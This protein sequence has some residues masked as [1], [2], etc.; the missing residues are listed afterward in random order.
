MVTDG[1]VVIRTLP[2]TGPNSALFKTRLY[3]GQRVLVLEGPVEADGYPWYRIRLG[4][5]EGWVAAADHDGTPWLSPVRNGAIAFAHDEPDGF[6][7]TIHTVGPD[8]VSNEA[9]LFSNES[10]VHFEQLT[11]SPDGQRLAFVSGHAEVIDAPSE[12]F[13]IDADGSNL[14]QVTNDDLF[15]DSPVWSPDGSR[16][17]FHQYGQDP[18]SGSLVNSEVV[19]VNADGSGLRV[20]GPGENPAWSPDGQSVAMTVPQGDTSR[21]WV[22]GADG[23]GRH[24]VSDLAVQAVAPAWSPDGQTLLVSTG[25]LSLVDLV[26]GSV[27]PLLADSRSSASPPSWS[28]GGLIAFSATGTGAPGLFTIAS[29]GSGLRQVLDNDSPEAIAAWSPD[30]RWLILDDEHTG[31][32]VTLVDAGSGTFVEIASSTGIATSAAWQALLP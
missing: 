25:G 5:I 20:L 21:A 8:G 2:E 17:A 7:E 3:P 10:L 24:Q 29:D 28:I 9:V 31:S 22:Q 15:D 30:G 18:L 13:A 11:W 27:T 1:R 14:V 16:L 4:V 26:T 19:V 23:T 32:P 6:S 12:I